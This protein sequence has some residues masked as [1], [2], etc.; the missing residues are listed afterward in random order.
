ME[1]L[2]PRFPEVAWPAYVA[3]CP[4][5]ASLQ[6]L[7][8]KWA[9]LVLR[10]IAF[11]RNPRFSDI[12]RKN[13]GLTPRV[14]SFR[15]KELEEEGFIRRRRTDDA[16]EVAYDLLP[17]GH[18]AIPVLAALACFGAK[19]HADQVFADGERRGLGEMFPRGR[20]TLLQELATWAPARAAASAP[21]RRGARARPTRR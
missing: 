8:R 2:P 7:G 20:G 18:D 15:L 14:L 11:D 13:P 21:K 17:K 19:H 12:L 9:I 3:S 16:R 1:P 6:A 5:G 4:I 10:D